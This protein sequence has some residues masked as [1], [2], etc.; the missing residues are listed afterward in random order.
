MRI[1]A[2]L[3]VAVAAAPVARASAAPIVVLGDGRVPQYA[4]ALGAA[5]AV[6][7]DAPLV[8]PGD[9]AA[10]QALAGARV[11][12]AVGQKAVQVAQASA[13][14]SLVVYCMVLRGAVRPSPNVT[15]VR[16]EVAPLAALRALAQLAPSVRRV[17]VV[18]DPRISNAYLKEAAPAASALGLSLVARPVRDPGEV[19]AALGELT[20]RVDALWLMP[21]PRLVSAELLPDILA[22]QSEHHVAVIGFLDNLTEAGALASVAP[23]YAKAGKLAAEMARD[24]AQRP[25]A[26]GAPLPVAA[27]GPGA[28]TINA[29]T[30]QQLGLHPPPA[31][32]QGARR[33]YR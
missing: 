29:K 18:Y 31:V 4:E 20:S 9:G 33:I 27:S 16:L 8:D 28:L 23:D 6:L 5:R 17:G 24:L 26:A 10:G 25:V 11:V 1:A 21:D 30:A 32:L 12:L 2:L 7:S 15:G 22:Q 14:S 13:P 3:A 19:R